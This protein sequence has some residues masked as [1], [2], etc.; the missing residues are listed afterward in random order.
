VPPKA[1]F[2]KANSIIYFKGDEGDKV[3]ILNSGQVSLTYE[4]IETGQEMRN[5]VKV[6][7][8][9]GV[10]S[11]LGRFRREETAL[12][13]ADC[14]VVA[15]SADEFDLLVLKN[16][17][18][19]LKMLKVYSNQLRRIQNQVQTMLGAEEH[20]DA[21]KGLFSIGDYYLRNKAY[22]QATYAFKRYLVFYPSGAAATQALK[23]IEVAEAY[24]TRYGPGK[25]PD[26]QAAAGPAAKAEPQEAV[27]AP[28]SDAEQRYYR[29][30]SLISQEKYEDALKEF[31]G[32]IAAGPDE[33]YLSKAQYESGRCLFYLKQ[34]DKAIGLFTQWVQKY[35]KHPD[36]RDALYFVGTSYYNMNDKT[37]AAGIFEKILT[38]TP[39]SESI[40]Q[41]TRKL[42]KQIEGVL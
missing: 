2:Y 21:A 1:A 41:K 33:E 37:K 25:G 42:L 26:A 8:F 27:K 20:I 13:L 36:L 14:Q 6:G 16:I 12:V 9:F 35:P 5:L 38:M 15:F 24:L 30:V 23:N 31:K 28:V 3:F 4:D 39:E 34:Y 11:A 7:E 17:P 19:I 29:A 40:Y 22:P 18:L 32:L 10:K